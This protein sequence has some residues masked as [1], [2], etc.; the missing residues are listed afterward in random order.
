MA[1]SFAGSPRWSPDGKLIIFY[2]MNVVDTHKARDD[3][4]QSQ[5][6][7]QIVSIDIETGARRDHT[8]GAGLKVTP[9]FLDGTRIEYLVKSGANPGITY[10]SGKR[11]TPETFAIRRGRVMDDSRLRPRPS[12]ARTPGL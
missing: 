7:S 8:S 2:Q 4:R 6:A 10:N 3:E 1:I 9:Q 11:G 12:R 5:V